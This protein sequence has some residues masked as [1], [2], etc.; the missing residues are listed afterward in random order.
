MKYEI[1][2]MLQTGTAAAIVNMSSFI[3]IGVVAGV[4]GDGSLRQFLS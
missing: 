3:L 1:K 4:I 2:L